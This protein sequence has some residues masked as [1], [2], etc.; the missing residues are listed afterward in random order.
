[1]LPQGVMRHFII[2]WNSPVRVVPNELD[3]SEKQKWRVV[4][5]YRKYRLPKL[6]ASWN[7]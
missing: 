4:I 5:D 6:Q 3:A 1:M 2:P 7:N